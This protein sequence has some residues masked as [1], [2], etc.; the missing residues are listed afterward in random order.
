MLQAAR[1]FLRIDPAL[2]PG[3]SI[4]LAASA[5]GST[6]DETKRRQNLTFSLS[7]PGQKIRQPNKFADA[8]AHLGIHQEIK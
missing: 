6:L 3:P 4:F 1:F 8:V 7:A 2:I 5:N